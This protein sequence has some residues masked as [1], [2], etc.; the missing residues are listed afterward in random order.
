MREFF[1]DIDLSQ[2]LGSDLTVLLVAP[3]PGEVSVVPSLVLLA[4]A[5]A[6]DVLNAVLEIVKEGKAHNCWQTARIP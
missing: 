4:H 6:P 2:V 3:D 1:G 5:K